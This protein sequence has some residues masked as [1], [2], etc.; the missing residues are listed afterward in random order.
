MKTKAGSAVLKKAWREIYQE[1][2]CPGYDIL[3]SADHAHQVEEHKKR[4]RFCDGKTMEEFASWKELGEKIQTITPHPKQPD[5]APG[6]I[7]S[8]HR[9]LGGW[10]DMHR[11]VNPPMVLVLEL[12][13]DVDGIRV[14]QIFDAPVLALADDVDL[15]DGFGH[16]QPWNTYALRKEDVEYCWGQVSPEMVQHIQA[17]AETEEENDTIDENNTI[18]FFRQFEIEVGATM[19]MQALPTLIHRHEYPDL[20]TWVEDPKKVRGKVLEFKP[21]TTLPETDNALVMFGA[22]QFPETMIKKAASGAAHQF[23]YNVITL[24]DHT[25]E[26]GTTGLARLVAQDIEDDTIH[27]EGWLDEKNTTGHL[28]AWWNHAG[29]FDEGEVSHDLESGYFE[30]DFTDRSSR[31]FDEGKLILLLIRGEHASTD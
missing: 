14:A 24:N 17:L 6:Q 19:A 16:A 22:M 20:P 11:H 12:L 27:V 31:E 26:T 30:I 10:D 8:L 1:R 7:W 23:S 18:Y 28:L 21:R 4:C 3:F 29:V 5:I 25:I 9:S 2:T 15:G 13:D